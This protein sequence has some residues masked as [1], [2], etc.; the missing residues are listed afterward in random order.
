MA[1]MKEIAIELENASDLIKWLERRISRLEKELR[2]L[3]YKIKLM[4]LLE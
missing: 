1:K 4:Q 2:K 3:K